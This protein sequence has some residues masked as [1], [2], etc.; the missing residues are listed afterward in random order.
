MRVHMCTFSCDKSTNAQYFAVA[1]L[2][3]ARHNVLINHSNVQSGVS[4]CLEPRLFFHQ[5]TSLFFFAAAKPDERTSCDLLFEM[6]PY[7][8]RCG[9]QG[10]NIRIF[11]SKTFRVT[12]W[13]GESVVT[14][15]WTVSIY[16]QCTPCMCVQVLVSFWFHLNWFYF[17]H[18]NC[19]RFLLPFITC[20]AYCTNCSTASQAA[21]KVNTTF[22]TVS[23]M[24]IL[25][26]ELTF[27]HICFFYGRMMR[28][29][30]QNSGLHPHPHLLIHNATHRLFVKQRINGVRIV[31]SFNVQIKCM[32][33]NVSIIG[34]ITLRCETCSEQKHLSS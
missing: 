3:Y 6:L 20:H 22:C 29:R 25:W 7:W 17:L 34:I 10:S 15:E 14:T 12:I 18:N 33:A 5:S 11:L 2:S 32:R 9:R 31:H 4:G 16:L 24:H 28:L 23:C 30:A 8:F 1:H 21:N 13:I 27:N 26:Q 19:Y